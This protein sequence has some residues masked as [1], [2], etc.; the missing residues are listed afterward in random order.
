MS[1]TT[2]R[3]DATLSE[4]WNILTN[5]TLSVLVSRST[6]IEA[7]IGAG[8]EREW[9]FVE[10]MWCDSL[11]CCVSFF[12]LTR[13][14]SAWGKVA[15]WRDYRTIRVYIVAKVKDIKTLLSLW[16]NGSNN[17]NKT[18]TCVILVQNQPTS[19]SN[20]SEL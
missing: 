8:R 15:S 16:R 20:S 4:M 19:G 7:L 13:V 14:S 11:F 3:I 2:E 6:R 18:R 9:S 12:I 1:Y 5:L 17:N 10:E